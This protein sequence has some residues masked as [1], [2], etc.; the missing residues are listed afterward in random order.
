MAF[1]KKPA[2]ERSSPQGDSHPRR[3]WR[4]HLT[5]GAL[6]AAIALQVLGCASIQTFRASP[7]TACI[8]DTVTVTWAATG[9]VVLNSDPALPQA[10]PHVSRGTEHFIVTQPTRFT[11]KVRRLLSCKEAEADV[12]VVPKSREFGGLATCSDADRAVVLSLPLGAPQVSSTLRVVSVTNKNPREIEVLKGTARSVLAAGQTSTAFG[13]QPVEGAWLLRAP[14]VT[15]E[16]CDSALSSV[17][18]RLTLQIN[19]SCGE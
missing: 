19:L 17:A 10:G 3:P 7:R 6:V 9:D 11:L 1:P 15:T 8:G 2:P 13:Q 5:E 18:N 16:T 14:L 4:N 12:A